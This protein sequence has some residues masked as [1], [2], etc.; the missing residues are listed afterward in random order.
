MCVFVVKT[1]QCCPLIKVVHAG[2]KLLC[3]PSIWLWPIS[4]ARSVCCV[5][6]TVILLFRRNADL[7]FYLMPGPSTA[8]VR[9][10]PSQSERLECLENRLNKNHQIIHGHPYLPTLYPQWMWRYQ[11]L[12]D[13]SEAVEKK[14]R[15]CRLRQLRVELLEKG[16]S[17]SDD[18]KML[19][20][21]PGQ[22]ISPRIRRI[23]R[24]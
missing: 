15:K 1:H 20:A 19:H 8:D 7:H 4:T 13:R 18:H 6:L 22:S 10:R 17:V 11:L 14:R 12:P 24:H 2:S 23:W 21:Y 9:R 3:L 16:F 5:K